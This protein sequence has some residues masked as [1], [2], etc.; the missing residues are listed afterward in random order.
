VPYITGAGGSPETGS[1]P[2]GRSTVAVGPVD[3]VGVDLAHAVRCHSQDLAR[4][5]R[6]QGTNSRRGAI[7]N[8][9][10]DRLR[11]DQPLR[12]RLA[13]V[14]EQ[15]PSACSSGRHEE[16]R[17]ERAGKDCQKTHHSARSPAVPL[18]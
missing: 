3:R 5:L 18:S 8:D 4:K 17:G 7:V 2:A 13:R 12:G 1:K 10:V 14:T 16:P 9:G 11:T 6:T 15:R